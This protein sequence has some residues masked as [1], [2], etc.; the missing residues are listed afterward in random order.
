M[1]FDL[2]PLPYPESGLEPHI[3]RTT[4]A[5]HHRTQHRGYLAR[6][7]EL[8]GGTPEAEESL[9]TV[10]L[11]AD[12]PVFDNAAQVWNHDFYWRSMRPDGGGEPTGRFRLALER[13]FGSFPAFRRAFLE[14]GASHFGSGWLWLVHYEDRL[15]VLT[16]SDA[17]LPMVYQAT[18]L[19]AAD[20]WEHAYY[21][22]HH[23]DRV[24]Y[25][26]A[27]FDHLIDWDFAAANWNEVAQRP[28]RSRI[29]H[30]ARSVVSRRVG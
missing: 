28:P 26:Q 3:G 1:D 10:I 17:D 11:N 4:L 24:K 12:G 14:A 23:D 9:E 20:L 15:R 2:A 16:T 30:P 6:L 22:D 19:L 7:K 27:F 8:I 13:D 18:A 5:L 25:L 29:A 21:L